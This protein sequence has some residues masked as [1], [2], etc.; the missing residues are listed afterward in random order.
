MG[1]NRENGEGVSWSP[2]DRES[3]A[4]SFALFHQR[5]EFLHDLGVLEVEVRGLAG[6][7]FQVIELGGGFG[8]GIKECKGKEFAIRIAVAAGSSVIEILPITASDGHRKADGLMQSVVALRRIIDSFAGEGGKKA[9]AVFGGFDGQ[10]CVGDL[11]AGSHDVGEADR[12]V[13]HT[14]LD[15]AG[16][17]HD[18]WHSVPPFPIVPLHATPGSRG[19]VIVVSTHMGNAGCLGAVV[20]AEED[21]SVVG[22]TEF[23]QR[24]HQFPNDEVKFHDE[25]AVRPGIAFALELRGCERR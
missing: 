8:G 14:W 23:L 22:D 11:G 16:P 21:E 6:I 4:A 12:G 25:V 2:P 15:M 7:G 3:T 5:L 19:V 13:G 20:A 18:E 17:M 24:G 10:L 9:D 1:M